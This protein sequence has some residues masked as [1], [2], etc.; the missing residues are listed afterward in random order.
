MPSALVE[1]DATVINFTGARLVEVV[2]W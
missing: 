2:Q 1:S